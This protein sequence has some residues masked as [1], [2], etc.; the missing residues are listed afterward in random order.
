[1]AQRKNTGN[2][3]QMC[4]RDRFRREHSGSLQLARVITH[5]FDASNR[6]ASATAVLLDVSKAFNKV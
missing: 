6:K 1:M 3:Q 5:L 4:I 2:P